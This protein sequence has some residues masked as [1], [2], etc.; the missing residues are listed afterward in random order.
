MPPPRPGPAPG[1]PV[2]GA[3]RP[4]P[5]APRALADQVRTSTAAERESLAERIAA[6]LDAPV[7]VAGIV[8]VLIIVADRMTSA[9]S[10][11]ATVWVV[12]GW[13]LWGLFVVE[14]V[15][16]AAIAPSTS[17]FLRR[18]WWQAAFLAVPFLRF[19]R[20]LS[21]PARLARVAST[22]VRTTR[23]AG[24][25]LLGRVGWLIGVTVGTILGGSELL[26]EYGDYTSYPR[27]LHDAALSAIAGE[28]LPT[29]STVAD[30][31][32]IVLAI[33]ATVIFAAL[34]GSLGAFFLE[35]RDV[36]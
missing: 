28:P 26:F 21:R 34:A 6:R 8:F 18:N 17:G 22:S 27:A 5:P 36:Q 23:T 3:G 16:R 1:V 33:H 14:F 30:V 9:G 35:R 15:L 25:T 31:L 10:P 4:R 2:R 13:A 29:R 11:L 32:E 7:T 12:A 24:R 19:L 20:A